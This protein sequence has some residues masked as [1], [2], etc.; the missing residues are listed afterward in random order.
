VPLAPE[1]AFALW[2]DVQ[3]WASFVEG[4]AHVLELK[5]DWPHAGS[6]LTW[7]SIPE[8]RG[9][10]LEQVTES[11][12]GQTFVTQVHEERLTGIQTV[13][14]A[15][16]AEGA[17][18]ELQLD[19]ELSREDGLKKIV[20]VLFVRRA[21]TDALARTLMRFRTEAIEDAEAAVRAARERR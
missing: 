3:R 8:G 9:T 1:A 11:L 20:D 12:P 13:R 5:G 18:V 21:L 16:D 15:E 10:V 2:T 17:Y 19:Y 7:K 6:R 4:F 14:F